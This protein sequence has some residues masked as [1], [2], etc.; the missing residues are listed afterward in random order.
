MVK[1]KKE[2]T[3]TPKVIK[4]DELPEGMVFKHQAE[5]EEEAE[6]LPTKRRRDK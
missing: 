3:V 6:L 2:K 5:T 4:S 1:E